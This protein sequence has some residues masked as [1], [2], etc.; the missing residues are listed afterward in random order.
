MFDILNNSQKVSK[1]IITDQNIVEKIIEDKVVII[2]GVPRAY[3][4]D[5]PVYLNNNP[6]TTFKRNYEE[7][8]RCTEQEMIIMIQDSSNESLDNSLLENFTIDDLDPEAIR[9]YRQ[10]FS[11]LKSEHPFTGLSDQDFLI[12]LKVLRKNRRTNILE[13]TLGGLLVFGKSEAIKERLPH[14]HLEYIDKSDLSHE[15]WSDRLVYDG[16]WEDNLY[17]FFYL[18]INKIYNNLEKNFKILEDNITREELSEVHIALREA[19]INS[20]IH[21]NF[22]VEQPIKVTK[23]P[24]YFQFENPG[25]L[26]ISKED[27]FEGEHS[28]PRNHIIQEIFRHLNLCERAGSGIPKILKAVKDYSYKY[29]DIEEDKDKF[30]F[31]FWNIEKIE[32]GKTQ[33]ESLDDLNKIEKDLL[34]YYN[35]LIN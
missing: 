13:L 21:A 27:F 10:R 34:I 8:Y 6:K 28:D 20:I 18:A 4:K 29:P 17:N 25:T 30:T 33:I 24:N 15:R 3:Y 9:S 7:D 5:K 19:F 32:D 22:E 31:K 16:T 14:F 11:L 26:R 12:K 35:G 1:N 2:I 23:Y